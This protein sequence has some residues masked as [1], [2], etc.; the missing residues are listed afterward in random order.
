MTVNHADT[1]LL[2]H[3][4]S[5][6]AQADPVPDLVLEM[7]RLAWTTRALDAELLELVEQ[8]TGVPVG[9]RS[10]ALQPRVLTFE[11]GDLLLDLQVERV[12]GAVRL[13]GQVMP[14]PLDGGTVTVEQPDGTVVTADVDDLGGFT[15]DG[16][17]DQLLRVRVELVGQRPFATT[18]FTA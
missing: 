12:D 4:G 1:E 9:V 3:L 7:A 14:F 8:S 13:V 6:A 10:T 5:V 17:G 18:W 2:V 15:A 11:G 16:L